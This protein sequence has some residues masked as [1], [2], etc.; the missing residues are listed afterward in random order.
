MIGYSPKI[1]FEAPDKQP[2]LYELE[3]TLPNHEEVRL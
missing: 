3:V 2:V 1:L